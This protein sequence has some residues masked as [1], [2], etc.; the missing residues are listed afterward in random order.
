[1]TRD[2]SMAWLRYAAE[3]AWKRHVGSGTLPGRDEGPQLAAR[4]LLA[5][6]EGTRAEPAARAFLDAVVRVAESG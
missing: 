6:S 2:G 3:T 4:Q 5:A 1:M